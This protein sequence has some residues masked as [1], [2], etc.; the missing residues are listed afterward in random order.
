MASTDITI[1]VGPTGYTGYTGPAGAGSTGPTGPAG[2][3]GTGATGYTGPQG[4]TGF[5]GYTGPGGAGSIGATG[6]TG[7][8]GPASSVTG[9]TGPAGSN[10]ATGPTGYTGPVGSLNLGVVAFQ[11]DQVVTVGDV[12]SSIPIPASLNGKVVTAVLA[13]VYDQGVTGATEIQLIRRRAGAEVNVLSSVVSLG[14]VYFAANGTIN[15][16]NDDLATGDELFV[17]VTQVHSGT[18]PNGLSVVIT[19]A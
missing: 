6:P 12:G 14:A 10:G 16:S 5:T 7:Y 4:A 3:G 1:P 9:P 19:V 17:E 13:T 18:P 2:A 15:T 8:T 11:N